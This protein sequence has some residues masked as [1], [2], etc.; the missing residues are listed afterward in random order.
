MEQDQKREQLQSPGQHIKA[1]HDL[2][3]VGKVRKVRH[4]SHLLQTRTHVV[5][6]RGHRRK[7]GHQI[8]SFQRDE[9][10][11]EHKQN[12]KCNKIFL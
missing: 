9:E 3:E 5:D 7:S 11:G 12:H 4:R 2:G 8:L 10:D 1:E 6:G